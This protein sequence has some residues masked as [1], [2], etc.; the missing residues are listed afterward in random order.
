MD[1][2]VEL[3]RQVGN[4]LQ[5]ALAH[6]VDSR[7]RKR[8]AISHHFI[9]HGAQAVEIRWG[10]NFFTA[11]LLRRHVIKD[12]GDP[13]RCLGSKVAD[14]GNSEAENFYGAVPTAHDLGGL[15]AVVKDFVSV[16][17]IQAAAD[18]AADVEQVPDGKSFLAG[19]HGGDAVALDVLHGGTKLAFDFA[20]AID[21]SDVR[22]AEDLASLGFFEQRLFEI[23]RLLSEG[24]ELNR[25]QC[26]GLSALRVVGL[27][28]RAGR[29]LRELAKNFEGADFRGH[30]FLASL[31]K[32]S[33]RGSNRSRAEQ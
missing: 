29:R 10:G 28:D 26:D 16:G 33:K 17:V 8:F 9:K 19:Q 30:F 18:L 6:R 2:W 3:Y 5:D 14:A 13:V 15:E 32:K 1:L 11:N 7:A 22:T 12:R 31:R 20:R 27:V 24:A 25:F 21:G 23:A 4:G